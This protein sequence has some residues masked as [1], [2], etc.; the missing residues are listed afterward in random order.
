[1]LLIVAYCIG[2]GLPFILLA[3]GS[4]RA[5]AGVG[6]LRRHSRS[7]QVAGGILLVI[8][9]IL[10]L[11]GQWAIFVEWIRDAFISDTTLPI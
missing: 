5:L 9:G 6:L 10:L 11:T 8:V 7:I 2:L 4:R 1:M 3:L